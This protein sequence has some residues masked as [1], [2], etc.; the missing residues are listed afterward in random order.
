MFIPF[1]N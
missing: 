1:S